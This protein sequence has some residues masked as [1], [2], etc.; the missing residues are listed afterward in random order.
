MSFNTGRSH[1]ELGLSRCA[2]SKLKFVAV[3]K[4]SLGPCDALP[5]NFTRILN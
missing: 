5:S 4:V 3:K 1:A 2:T